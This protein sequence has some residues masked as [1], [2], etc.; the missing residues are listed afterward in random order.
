MVKFQNTMAFQ[1]WFGLYLGL[2]TLLGHFLLLSPYGAFFYHLY[3][4]YFFALVRVVFDYSFGMLPW[5]NVYNILFLISLLLIY[6]MRQ[7]IKTYTFAV[8]KIA[9]INFGKYVVNGLGFISF[10]FYFLWAFNYYRPSIDEELS[11]SEVPLD[12]I[13]LYKELMDVTALLSNERTIITEDTNA[14]NVAFKWTDVEDSIRQL[15]T[16]MLRTWG[17]PAYGNV[18]VRLIEPKGSLL[19]FSTAG[20]YIPFSGEG[21]IDPGMNHIQW[22]FTA[23]HEMAHG[24]GYTDEGVCNFIGLLT[25]LKSKHAFIKYAGLIQYW[26]YIFVDVRKINP[27]FAE[28]CFQTLPAGVRADLKAIRKDLDRYPDILPSVRDFLYDSYLKAHGV[29]TGLLSY[30]EITIQ[31]QKWRNSKHYFTFDTSAQTN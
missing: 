25:C 30:N 19:R 31:V 1:K 9:W 12:S 7:I 18:R 11:L 28:Q 13:T 29:K 3:F 21:H 14:L 23:A 27:N 15:Q 16:E 17:N 6:K 8:Q 22:P 10:L 5:A 26:K 4:N 20:I 24:Y 2:C